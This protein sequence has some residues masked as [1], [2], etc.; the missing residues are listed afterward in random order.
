MASIAYKE[1]VVRVSAA[2]RARFRAVADDD[3][4]PQVVTLTGEC[5]RCRDDVE[6]KIHLREWGLDGGGDGGTD[7]TTTVQ[8]MAAG[9]VIERVPIKGRLLLK[10]FTE[11]L[12]RH[13]PP[14]EREVTLQCDCGRHQHKG[15][16]TGCG[17]W[18]SLHLKWERQDDKAVIAIGAGRPI[19][20]LEI[21]AAKDRDSRTRSELERLRKAAGNWKTG[22]AALL[23]LLP[24]L[25]VV[26]G[27]DSV[28]DLSNRSKGIVG[29]FTALGALLAVI[30][31]LLALRASY[32]S[33]ERQ[34]SAD[35]MTAARETEIDTTLDYLKWTRRLTVAAVVL[36][37]VAIGYAWGAPSS[38]PANFAVTKTDD[39]V[40]CGTY[41]A[42]TTSAVRVKTSSGTS[43]IPLEQVKSVAFKT[44]C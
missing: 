38:D 26:K 14:P 8:T 30:A 25:V 33:L 2:E 42:P 39:S 17:A 16:P 18:F 5:P 40:V 3:E 37:A 34:D 41:V 12:E 44:K 24:T 36:L 9:D 7:A 11:L 6:Y 23:A 22:L 28:A 31:A 43:A 10:E 20:G 4:N 19:T 27:T 32:G 1:A 29:G 15:A 13:N 35:D 21:A